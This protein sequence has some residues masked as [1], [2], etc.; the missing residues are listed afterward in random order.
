MADKPFGEWGTLSFSIPLADELE[1]VRVAINTVT[2]FLL[3]GLNIAVEALNLVKTFTVSYLNPVAEIVGAIVDELDALS[4]SISDI[5]LYVAGDWNLLQ[6]PFTELKGG[7]SEYE[8]RMIAR[9]TDR[10]D[11][12]RPDVDSS[13]S[14]FAGFF[15]LSV[16]SSE[17]ERL[18]AFIEQITQFFNLSFNPKGGMPTPTIK[19]VIYG[20]EATSP[21]SFDTL[22]NFT[23]FNDTPPQVA[24]VTWKVT[25]PTTDSP[26]KPFPSIPPEHFLITVS[27]LPEGIPLMYDRARSNADTVKSKSGK[28]VQP[29]QFGQVLT[30]QGVP[31]VLH[32][33]WRMLAFSSKT[34][35]WEQGTDDDG[36]VK[37]GKARVYGV[38]DPAKNSIIPLEKLFYQD[39]SE[40]KDLWQTTI[41]SDEIETS[42]QWATDEFSIALPIEKLPW[43]ATVTLDG[44]KAE[45]SNV[46]RPATYYVRVA[47]TGPSSIN[48]SGEVVF[49]YDLESSGAK[50]MATSSAPF[51]ID[52]ASPTLRS[53]PFTLSAWSESET[54]TFPNT[55]TKDYLDAVKAA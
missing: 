8:R 50:E 7:F 6:Y 52:V 30:R 10:T 23:K 54:V 45:I 38:E 46:H 33:G 37:N 35:G 5:G 9:L 27:T 53:Q 55:F 19:E 13:I 42:L 48:D 15:Y 25:P 34:F 31:V 36:D 2:D 4:R 43:H 20:T 44:N 32:G 3:A 12:T 47:S 21:L 11:P 1:P 28:K 29:R 51:V 16:E 39:G 49:R 14:T 18:I 22:D 41:P 17:I 24:R 40:F 26:F